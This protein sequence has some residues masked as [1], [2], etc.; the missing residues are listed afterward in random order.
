MLTCPF[1]VD[2]C[3]RFGDGI[4]RDCFERAAKQRC[5]I[6]IQDI[7]IITRKISGSTIMR[8]EDYAISVEMIVNEVHQEH[9][10]PVQLHKPQNY[11]VVHNPSLPEDCFMLAIQTEW[12][13]Q[14]YEINASSILGIDSTDGTNCCQW[15]WQR[16]EKYWCM[17]WKETTRLRMHKFLYVLFASLFCRTV[18]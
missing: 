6:K 18:L 5:L 14:L 2:I 15:V 3:S 9:F 10:N 12:Q 13:K 4:K 16:W 1:Q 7:S 17:Y 8:D 11:K